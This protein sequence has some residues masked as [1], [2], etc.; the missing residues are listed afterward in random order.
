MTLEII[1]APAFEP[2]TLVQAKLQA[3][4]DLDDEDALFTGIIIPGV[5]EE[6]EQILRRA[7]MSQALR[8]TLDGFPGCEIR[9]PRPKLLAVSGISY[10]DLDGAWQTLDP[11]LYEVHTASTPGRVLRALD[12]TWPSTYALPGSVRVNYTAGYLAGTEQEQQAAVPASV[13]RWMLAR[14]A[15]AYQFREELLAG[16]IV[17]QLPGRFVDSAL[18]RECF[19]GSTHE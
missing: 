6:C 16:T 5:R 19:Y 14:I 7:I 11:S 9:L 1:T 15:T 12:A 13:K 4:V 2:V 8:L 18:D 17:S 10:R 3:R